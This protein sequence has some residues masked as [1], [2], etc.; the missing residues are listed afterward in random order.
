MLDEYPR[1]TELRYRLESDESHEYSE[2]AK[3]SGELGLFGYRIERR[4][5]YFTPLTRFATEVEARKALEPHLRAWETATL[6][7]YGAGAM[8]FSFIGAHL[9]EQAPTPGV[10]QLQGAVMLMFGSRATLTAIHTFIPPPP[11]A[12]SSNDCVETL[13]EYYARL[14]TSP[15]SLLHIAYGMNSCLAKTHTNREK[16]A[17]AIS[18]DVPVLKRLSSMSSQL[19]V[20]AE[21]R[22]HESDSLGRPPRE[23]EREWMQKILKEILSRSGAIAAGASPGP[24]ITLENSNAPAWEGSN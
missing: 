20:G 16:G 18:I 9:L 6:L 4:E 3:L 5:C 23:E 13:S 8:R 12:F 2:A 21:A 19:G 7:A 22:K 10:V 15:P 24:L 11:Q 17:K 14:I 1:V